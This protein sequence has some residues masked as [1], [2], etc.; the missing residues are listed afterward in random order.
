MYKPPAILLFM[1]MAEPIYLLANGLH[2]N[3]KTAILFAS[4]VLQ[5]GAKKLSIQAMYI[6]LGCGNELAETLLKH[7][8]MNN[9]NKYCTLFPDKKI[10]M[11]NKKFLFLTIMVFTA[12]LQLCFA[13]KK[14]KGI[15][16]GGHVNLL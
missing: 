5:P 8:D 4:P 14:S 15:P 10:K 6:R 1:M 3:L 13:Q 12:N 11:K 7:I 2:R 9:L 16:A